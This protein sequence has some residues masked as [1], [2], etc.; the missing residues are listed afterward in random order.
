[1]VLDDHDPRTISIYTTPTFGRAKSQE[2][3]IPIQEN[4][5]ELPIY[6][7]S[8]SLIEEYEKIATSFHEKI[9]LN[10]KENKILT[11]L[12]DTLLP[13]LISGELKISDAENMV[14]EA[15]I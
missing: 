5:I 13:K 1:M 8:I 14:E 2:T 3:N 9:S 6:L 15:G 7:S 11:S 12:R 4:L 10:K